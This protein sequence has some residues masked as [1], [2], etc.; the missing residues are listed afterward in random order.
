MQL[1]SC[2]S[3]RLITLGESGATDAPRGFHLN[4][5]GMDELLPGG[6]ARGAVHEVLVKPGCRMARFFALLLAR[7]ATRENRAQENS[8]IIWCDASP[9]YPPAVAA[10]GIDVRKLY[11]VRPQPGRDE[12]WALAECLRCEGV[13]AT[14]GVLRT[15]SHVEARRLQLA[16][17]AGGGIGVLMR[18]LDSRASVYAA[19]TRWLVEP[20][21]GERTVQRWKVRLIHG[22]G[23]RTEQI[24]LR[25]RDENA[26][27]F[28]RR[29]SGVLP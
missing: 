3:G 1:I 29:L 23:G 2:H 19:A 5:E 4:M 9:I 8:A 14:L 12:H 11:L 6:L 21:R 17:E 13:A 15:L 24:A 20:A 26:S 22:H 10:A 16:A 18:T 27:S 25:E 28:T 7:A